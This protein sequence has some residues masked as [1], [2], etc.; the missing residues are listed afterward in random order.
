MYA[1]RSYYGHSASRRLGRRASGLRRAD[2]DG[3]GDLDLLVGKEPDLILAPDPQ[4]RLLL[5]D[6]SGVFVDVTAQNLPE[7][8]DRGIP[9]LGDLDRDGDLDAIVGD[10]CTRLYTNLI[11]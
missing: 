11:V 9:M 6:G 7:D 1:I 2:L 4:D 8:R 10:S 5:N 3:D